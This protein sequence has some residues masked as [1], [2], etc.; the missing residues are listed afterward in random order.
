[1]SD[2][3]EAKREAA[4]T[5]RQEN[6]RALVSLIQIYPDPEIRTPPWW[7][8]LAVKYKNRRSRRKT[9]GLDIRREGVIV[10][11]GVR[12][13]EAFLEE[14]DRERS[15]LCH[16]WACQRPLGNRPPFE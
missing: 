5:D 7:S 10:V 16:K 3:T 15:D 6:Q 11:K 2:M 12:R 8:R 4:G 13:I 14:V 9:G 1:M